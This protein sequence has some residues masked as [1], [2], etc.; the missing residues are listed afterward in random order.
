MNSDLKFSIGYFLP[1]LYKCSDIVL[2]H[3]EQIAE[4]YF[5]WF[6]AVSG[7]GISIRCLDEQKQ[8][9]CE[10]IKIHGS[11][12]KLNLL[13]NSN[14]YGGKAV[15]AALEKQVCESVEYLIVNIGIEAVTTASLFIADIIKGR[16]PQIEVRASVNMGIGTISGIKYVLRY[17]DSFYLKRE[18]NRSFDKIKV[19]HEYCKSEG[20]KLY[21]L[22]NSGCLKN[23]S[24][25]TF[26][27][28]LVAHEHELE[29]KEITDS[30]FRGICWDYYSVSANHYSFLADSSWVRPEDINAYTGL[31][32]GIKLATRAHR[33]P[34]KVIKAYAERK[35][36]GNVLSLSEPDFSGIYY[37]DNT[38]LHK[39]WTR[40]FEEM[41]E[42][43]HQQYCR[44]VLKYVN[45]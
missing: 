14:C 34:E 39:K 10:L 25:H 35:F 7:R 23:C 5:P 40:R 9:E 2:E 26:H 20:K 45:I 21:M 3:S 12:I 15:S 33:N 32:D 1:D 31:V 13:W 41:P 11:G 19:L 16:F 30:G 42:L 38:L 17:F 6:G 43:E 8:M 44:E 18:L 37:I 22:A 29:S 27:D 28:N 36:D 4:V 24:A